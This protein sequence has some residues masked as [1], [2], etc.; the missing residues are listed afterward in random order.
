MLE[1]PLKPKSVLYRAGEGTGRLT[2]LNLG[3]QLAYLSQ[4]RND[5]QKAQASP[6]EHVCVFFHY[7]DLYNI[8]IEARIGED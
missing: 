7:S 6:D 4:R 1:N 5:Q 2:C 8:K 3:T